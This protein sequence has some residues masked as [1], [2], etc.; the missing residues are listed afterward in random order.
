LEKSTLQIISYDLKENQ[1]IY[2]DKAAEMSVI[3]AG[4]KEFWKG[5]NK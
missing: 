3:L 2:L 5:S 1:T 4:A